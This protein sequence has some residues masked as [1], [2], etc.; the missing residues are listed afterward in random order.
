MAWHARSAMHSLNL[1]LYTRIYTHPSIPLPVCAHIIQPVSDRGEVISAWHGGQSHQPANTRQ[2]ST[3]KTE[4][5]LSHP[6][7]T[8]VLSV[9][10]SL[11]RCV[12]NSNSPLVLIS[13]IAVR[14][15]TRTDPCRV[16]ARHYTRARPR[17]SRGGQ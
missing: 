9:C 17:R 16:P 6:L 5:K 7:Q 4:I 15:H 14:T 8:I 2:F 3:T 10:G 13:L 1:Y 11:L 12:F